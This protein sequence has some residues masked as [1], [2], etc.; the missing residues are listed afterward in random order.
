MRTSWRAEGF[1]HIRKRNQEVRRREFRKV[2]WLLADMNVA[3]SYTLDA[4]EDI[5]KHRETSIKGVLLTLKLLEWT[6]AD[7]IPAYLRAHLIL[8]LSPDYGPPVEP[9]PG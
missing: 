1:K 8:G 5:V 6:L 7:G 2:R 3:P 9:P 4:V